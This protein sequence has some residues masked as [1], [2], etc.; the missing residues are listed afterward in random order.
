[1][2]AE[3]F[4]SLILPFVMTLS[5]ILPIISKDD[6]F[7]AFLSGCTDGL[8]TALSIFPTLLLLVVAVK[9]FT[10]SGAL[11]A[12][13]SIAM[14]FMNFFGIPADMFPVVI[15]RPI[16][17]SG[18]TAT[19]KELFSSAGPDSLSGFASSV[20]MGSSD[21]IIYTV[22]MY[23]AHINAKKTGFTL[24]VSFIVLFFCT[25][26]SCIAARLFLYSF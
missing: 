20:L 16:S 4:A 23:F 11:D 19:V 10:A 24:P 22:S 7:S 5:S 12:L 21:T 15:M 14:P 13:C 6:L 25:C 2:T 18:A 3:F 26:L 17:G 9:M 1:M 8:K